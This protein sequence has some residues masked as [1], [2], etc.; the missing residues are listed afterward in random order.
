VGLAPP[1]PGTITLQSGSR[2]L[3]AST[4]AR[5]A[6]WPRDRLAERLSAASY[7]TIL[8]LAALALIDADD[9]SS[10]LGWGLVTGVGAATWIAHLYAE[11]VG[12]HLRHGSALDR[13][14]IAR[15]AVDGFPILLAAVPP[16]V[17]LLLGRLEVLDEGGAL[18]ASLVIAVVQLVGIGAYVGSVVSVRGAN[19]WSYAAATAAIGMAVVTL[20]LVLGH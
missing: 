7:G 14:E 10:G 8:V 1:R 4:A 18:G 2:R 3:G 6:R 20:K 16:A 17:M 13:T 12:D 15:A 9:V 5:L 19:A 11:L